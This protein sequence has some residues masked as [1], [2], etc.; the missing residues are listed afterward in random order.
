MKRLIFLLAVAVLGFYV[1]WP[2][3]SVYRIATAVTDQDETALAG[4][5]DFAA[6]QESL[7]PVAM[8]EIGKRIDKETASLGPLGQAVAANLKSQMSGKIVDQVLAA[9]V[10]PRA[11]IRIANEG[12]DLAAS[13]EKA[14]SEATGQTKGPSGAPTDAPNRAGGLGGIFGQAV[15]GAEIA[16]V[17]GK[18]FGNMTESNAAKSAPPATE[19]VAKSEASRGPKRTFGL[20]NIKGFGMAGPLSFNVAVA[21]DASQSK[22]DAT[23]GMSFTGGDWKLTRVVPNL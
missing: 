15:E 23:V 2:A 1:A 4:K 9:V 10:T 19:T 11:I 3:W 21:R 14:M 17:A 5:I 12:G 18:A 8:T 16:G 20:G 22:P 13:V 7:R 6:L